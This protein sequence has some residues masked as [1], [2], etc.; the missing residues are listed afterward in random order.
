MIEFCEI[1]D[2]EGILFGAVIGT[3]F[4]LN[5]LFHIPLWIGVLITGSSTLLLLGLQRY[6]V[7]QFCLS[8][9]SKSS[10]AFLFLFLFF[11]FLTLFLFISYFLKKEI[12]LIK[13]I[14]KLH[15]VQE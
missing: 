1:S 6:G 5:I 9:Q 3:A 13:R 7:I 15:I 10:F 8:Y 4:A 12:W 11:F 14:F 2:S